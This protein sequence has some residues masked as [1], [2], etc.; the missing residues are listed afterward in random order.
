MNLQFYLEKLRNTDSFK[1]FLKKNPKAFLCSGF[2]VVPK[3]EKQGEKIHLDFF[4]P[5]KE[6]VFSFD[7]GENGKMIPLEDFEE[8]P[9][10]VSQKVEMDFNQIEKLVL[11]EMEKKQIKT[12]IQ[13]LIFSLQSREGKPFIFGT[14]FIPMLGM[15]KFEIDLKNKK[16]LDLE[17]KS[18]FDMVKISSKKKD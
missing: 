15:I 17:K 10:E 7:L 9:L 11:E 4:S 18:L 14:A 13:K 1:N 16:V 3:E 2:F 8:K 6:K 5:E 12:K